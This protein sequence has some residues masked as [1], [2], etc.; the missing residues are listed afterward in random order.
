MIG[1]TGAVGTEVVRSL[2]NY[3]SLQEL[4][5]LNRRPVELF[6]DSRIQSHTVD[7]YDPSSYRD[8]IAGHET[9]ICTLG[10]GQPSQISKAEFLRIDRQLVVDFADEV[11]RAGIKHFQLLGSVG[12]SETSPSF[13]L[14]AK[15]T[16][17]R[18]LIDLEFDRLSLFQPSMIITPHNRYGI[19]Q[20]VT[21]AVWPKLDPVLIGRLQKYRGIPVH[22]LGDAIA[23]NTSVTGIGVEVLQWDAIMRL[24]G[25]GA[26]DKS[27]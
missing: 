20:A 8:L 16:L 19:T 9:A 12:A 10:V 17:E 18:G 13:F 26:A 6:S 15:G 23:A 25:R 1:A 4:T 27:T 5:L 3:S 22:A 11:K 7:L 2:L 14:R 24:A 21:L